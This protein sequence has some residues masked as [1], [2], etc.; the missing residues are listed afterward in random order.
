MSD[1]DAR[2]RT[3]Q[4]ASWKPIQLEKGTVVKGGWLPAMRDRRED[5]GIEI[6]TYEYD[7][8]GVSKE[9]V[10]VYRNSLWLLKLVGGVDAHKG[11]F[12]DVTVV[13]TIRK[14]LQ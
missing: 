5:P 2:P 8:E 6:T 11:H 14:T 13:D 4:K 7:V 10:P 12:R 3:K 1:D 9:F